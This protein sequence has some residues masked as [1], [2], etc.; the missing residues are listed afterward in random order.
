MYK[1]VEINSS[2]I[3]KFNESNRKGHIFQ[4][5]Y[6]AE[7]KKD[8]KSKFVA[9]YDNDNNVVITATILL[10]KAPYINK[11]MGYIPRSFTCDYNNKKLLI[12]F[13]EYLRDF[14]KKN[15][16]SFITIDPDIHLNENEKE[17][18]EGAE[19][20]NF[21]KSLGYKNTDS[22]NFE[23]IQPNF[24]FRLP[25][26]TE[27]DKMDIKKAVF[28]KFS[29]KTRYNI[30]VAEERGLSV[31]VYDK[32]TLNEDVLDRFHE[33]MVTTG[34]R[35]NFLVRHREY[36]KDMIDYLY[37]HCRLYMVKYSYENDFSRLSEKLKKQE[38]AKVKALKK[39]EELKVKFDAETDEDKKSRVEKKLNDQDKRLK[40]AERQIEGFQKKIADIEPFKGQEIYLSGSI[41]LY[42]G[43][44]AWYLYGASE[45]ILRDTMPNFAMQWSMICDSIDLG[46]DVYDF[47]GVSGDLNPENPLYGLY[48][49]K[50]GFNGNFVEFIGEFDIVVDNGIYT[51]YK[52]AF[53]QF[54]KIRNAIM[55]KKQ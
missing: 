2:E 49:F 10:R 47:R 8:W 24:V 12:E 20:K 25:L 28:K 23:A 14:A 13:T 51:L 26:P 50:K 39:I 1:F 4:T 27:G 54:K 35:D 52:K 36:F 7:L 53:P 18:T 48:K 43:N 30:K 5:S 22:K 37:P 40:E 45:N 42:Y 38:D 31:E 29:S 34:K 16:I 33:I 6:W 19:I 32:E 9:G 3:D 17:L 21:L 41:Y 55:N 44:K 15:N 11:Y 46:C